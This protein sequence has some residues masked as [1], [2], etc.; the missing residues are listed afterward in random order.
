MNF[1][2]RRYQLIPFFAVCLATI[3]FVY[4]DRYHP[5][6]QLRQNLLGT[7]IQVIGITF[8]LLFITIYV[9]NRKWQQRLHELS[10][11][12]TQSKDEELARNR[13]I[14][15]G[16]EV[17]TWDWNLQTGEL[18]L[19]ERW[20]G[21]L[22]YT[23]DELKPIGIST[24]ERTV[25][26]DDM[27]AAE[28]MRKQHL[29]G[30]SNYY[31]AQFRQRHK[32]G[33]WR[34]INARGKVLEWTAEGEPLRMSGTHMDIT[35]QKQAELELNESRM[36]LCRVLDT[37]PARVFWKDTNCIFLGCNQL[38]AKDLGQQSSNEIIGK[39]DFD[40]FSQEEAERFQ[41]D[42]QQV[43]H[44]GIAKIAYEERLYRPNGEIIWLLTSKVPLRDLH[45]NTIGVLGT[46]ED[47]T[48]RKQTEL[49]LIQAK[50]A[51]EAASKAKSEFLAVMSHEMRTPLNP[52]LGFADILLENCTVEPDK[53]YLKT[54][55]NSGRRQLALIDDILHYM[56]IV[57]DR[58]EPNLERFNLPEFCA[59]AM[60][61]LR[62]S[63][64]NLQLHFQNDTTGQVSPTQLTVETDKQ[65]LHRIL[66]NLL[67]NSI[68]YTHAGSVTLRLSMESTPN[69]MF[70]FA[71]E[72][73]GIGIEKSQQQQLFD[74]FS[75]VDASYTRK[76]E[77]IGL[78]LAICKKLI[79][80]LDGKIEV[81]STL[82]EGSTFTVHLPLKIVRSLP[83]TAT[84][85]TPGI[86][87]NQF[88]GKP[89]ILIVDDKPDNLLI[90]KALIEFYNGQPH[91]ASNGKEAIIQ[92]QKESFDLILMDLSMPIMGGTEA[93]A[94]IRSHDTS[95]QLT[96]IVAMT[97]NVDNTAKKACRDAGMN[98]FISKPI[99]SKIFFNTLNGLLEGQHNSAV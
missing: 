63:A 45:D 47:I 44:S 75:Q 35:E 43:M 58:V 56:R 70:H 29:R 99:Q 19:N 64:R 62:P 48:L 72:D 67:N 18:V 37:I 50:E 33:E 71:I 88:I 79:E 96:P 38:I 89:N 95:N 87:Q 28:N 36:M 83:K 73:S 53:S 27:K 77:G 3:L 31:D 30:E 91:T 80:L 24:W 9:S 92:C 5:E 2:S 81:Q 68:K 55:I 61:E 21:I 59:A 78:G 1:S 14:I 34:W 94:W 57:S 65:M 90:A 66:E 69:T 4:I 15:E 52:I 6:Q 22:G 26:P 82:G 60:D 11:T 74:P 32:N 49:E 13:S 12:I 76:H 98:A 10:Q 39:T 8:P 16:T 93:C 25:H 51:A 54:I 41:K 86:G 84:A 23:L 17:G 46:Y 7:F 20:A 97:A 42:D 40:F 85:D